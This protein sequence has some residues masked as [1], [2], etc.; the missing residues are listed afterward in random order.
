MFSSSLLVS[1]SSFNMNKKDDE[2]GSEFFTAATTTPSWS[3]LLTLQNLTWP[4]PI[5]VD[6]SPATVLSQQEDGI[7]GSRRSTNT[8]DGHKRPYD[9]YNMGN[10]LDD[11]DE[12]LEMA[13]QIHDTSNDVTL[14]L[15]DWNNK[16]LGSTQGEDEEAWD[17]GAS[18]Q[19]KA[20][21][22]RDHHQLED[23][24]NGLFPISGGMIRCTPPASMD[25]SLSLLINGKRFVTPV[26]DNGFNKSHFAIE[27]EDS[28][29]NLIER[30]NDE[31][32]TSMEV[33]IPVEKKELDEDEEHRQKPPVASSNLANPVPIAILD[34]YA[35][36]DSC[37][38]ERRYRD[39]QAKLWYERLD[40]LKEF[41]RTY[42]HCNVPHTWT[43]N[44]KLA[45]WVKRQRYQYKL[46]HA[47]GKHSAM[48]KERVDI[49]NGMGFVWDIHRTSWEGKFVQLQAYSKEHG[50]T[51]ITMS[52]NCTP[53][54]RELSVWMKCQ[55][56]AKK[57][58]DRGGK[59]TITI[60]RINKLNSI[61]FDW[62]PRNL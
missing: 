58:H 28:V 21:Y 19:K 52:K 8:T 49:L 46:F 57:R 43:E 12:L 54:H 16:V 32:V 33:N 60:D 61:G 42:G 14:L 44:K 59:S 29:S 23:T 41:H 36:D 24:S 40:E 17:I 45:Q 1:S 47:T 10:D 31:S 34:N 56:H 22:H 11:F 62:N 18:M 48:S 51:N 13:N 35:S 20:K 55:R 38:V 15:K 5:G 4:L 9:E 37:D 25:S 6:E 53:E 2:K 39:Y 26:L 50:T 7:F 3:P 30:F 27:S